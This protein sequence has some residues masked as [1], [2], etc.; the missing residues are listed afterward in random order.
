MYDNKIYL[1][2]CCIIKAYICSLFA[3]VKTLK[4]NFWLLL[5][6]LVFHCRWL[7]LEIECRLF[8]GK[9]V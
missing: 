1:N 6:H 3:N 5:V 9:V 2:K 8:G 7:L 4:Y